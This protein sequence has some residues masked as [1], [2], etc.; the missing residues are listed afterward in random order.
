MKITVVALESPFP[1]IHGGRVDIWRRLQVLSELGVSIQLIYWA[2]AKLDSEDEQKLATVVDSSHMLELNGSS[3]MSLLRKISFFSRYPLEISSRMVCGQDLRDLKAAVKSFSPDVVMIDHLHGCMAGRQLSKYLQVPLILR[4]HNIEHLYCKNLY[5]SAQGYR[6]LVRLLSLNGLEKLEKETLTECS[7]FY[8]I[9][10]DDLE[11]WRSLGFKHGRFLPPTINLAEMKLA[12]YNSTSKNTQ[13][14]FDVVFLG[15][16]NTENNVAGL[17]WFLTE[18]AP[19]L[20]DKE[21]DIKILISGSNPVRKIIDICASLDYVTLIANPK[22]AA[23]IYRSGRVLINPMAVGGGVSIKAIDM[24]SA[25]RP[26]VTLPKGV[27]GLPERS[28]SLFYIAEDSESFA[29]KILFCLHEHLD[30]VADYSLL[31]DLFGIE[32]IKTFIKD[33]EENV[34]TTQ[35]DK[36]LASK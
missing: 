28:K 4:S 31:D 11:Y 36:V 6:K 30:N 35:P 8:D 19:R 27:G 7:A 21:P 20:K 34:L 5:A 25:A 13:E 16:L 1:P 12:Q 15:N 26:I 23:D 18:V 32:Q 29:E 10:V 3:F 2:K 14:E 9:S 33:L 17:V 22:S 24:L